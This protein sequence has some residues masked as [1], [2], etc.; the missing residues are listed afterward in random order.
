MILSIIW[1]L[2][3]AV[4]GAAFFVGLGAIVMLLVVGPIRAAVGAH[5]IMGRL[6]RRARAAPLIALIPRSVAVP[7]LV[8]AA[9]AVLNAALGFGACLVTVEATF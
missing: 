4:D 2:N 9:V 1:I 5:V 6:P 8:A 3:S 7:L